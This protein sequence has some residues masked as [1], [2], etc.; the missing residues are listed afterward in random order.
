MPRF[1]PQ[2]RRDV[3]AAIR[4]YDSTSDAL[5]NDFWTKFEQACRQV[6]FHPERF[7]APTLKKPPITCC[8]AKNSMACGS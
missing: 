1:H 3:T 4:H 6:E 2:V 5:G 7:D 8:F